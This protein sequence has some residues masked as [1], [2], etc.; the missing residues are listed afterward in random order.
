M[1][2]L[3]NN[4]IFFFLLNALRIKV[5]VLELNKDRGF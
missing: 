1:V 5:L 2:Y 3:F 4:M